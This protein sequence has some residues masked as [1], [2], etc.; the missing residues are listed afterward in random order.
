MPPYRQVLKAIAV[1][2]CIITAGTVGLVLIEGWSLLDALYMAVITVST[3]GYGEIM[4]LSPE[5]KAFVIVY[6]IIGVGAFL[7]IISK[8][9]EYIVAGHL[10]GVLGRKKM[11]KQIDR[12]KDHY[13]ICGFGRVGLQ[14]ASE[15]EGEGFDFVVV[16][17]NPEAIEKCRAHGYLYVEGC[18]SDDDV[19]KAAGILR[20]KGLVAAVDS[21]AENVYVTLSAK[22]L[23]EDI[24]IVA[25]ASNDEA[26][27]KLLRAHADRVIS[28]YTIG[29]RRLARMLIRPN[30]VEFLD[31]VMHSENTA[32]FM[33]E[34][35]V[36]KGSPLAGLTVG[37]AK[38]RCVAGANILAMKK[39]GDRRVLPS[40]EAGMVINTGDLLI[41]MGTREQ[42]D[43][44]ERLS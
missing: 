23:K 43:E 40:P 28:P 29:G 25:R 14:V 20:A 9:A 3:V 18:A 24:Y 44:L 10:Q 26:E 22:S 37:E 16:D 5:G 8:T 38:A 30:V 17:D 35:E 42:L 39:A 2:L 12:L 15:F 36:K 19:L 4:P 34:I 21:D 7:Y 27:G 41:A 6:I 13:I 33:E 11:L 1:I 32:L 31:V